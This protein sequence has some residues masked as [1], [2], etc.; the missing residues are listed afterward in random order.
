MK[1]LTQLKEFLKKFIRVKKNSVKLIDIKKD[2]FNKNGFELSVDSETIFLLYDTENHQISYITEVS[3]F[4][5]DTE[6]VTTKLLE[7]DSVLGESRFWIYKNSLF[8]RSTKILDNINYAEFSG[9]TSNYL[10]TLFKIKNNFLK[11]LG[12]DTANLWTTK[13]IKCSRLFTPKS[14]FESDMITKIFNTSDDCVKKIFQKTIT[15][16]CPY[17]SGINIIKIYEILL[18]KLIFMLITIKKNIHFEKNE[19]NYTSLVSF[20]SLTWKKLL[21]ECIDNIN[22][23]NNHIFSV[24]LPSQRE[25]KNNILNSINALT[26][27][28]QMLTN[29]FKEDID[30]EKLKIKTRAAFGEILL[31]FK[32]ADWYEKIEADDLFPFIMT[33]P[34]THQKL[35][36]HKISSSGQHLIFEEPIES[37]YTTIPLENMTNFSVLVDYLK[38]YFLKI[39]FC[40]FKFK[41]NIFLKN[42]RPKWINFISKDL[43]L[44]KEKLLSSFSKKN[45][46]L[47]EAYQ[48]IGIKSFLNKLIYQLTSD[49]QQ[50]T[51]DIQTDVVSDRENF[52]NSIEYLT[53][54]FVKKSDKFLLSKNGSEL[55][56]IIDSIESLYG[57][58]DLIEKI[59]L[60]TSKKIIFITTSSKKITAAKNI[61]DKILSSM[62]ILDILS[63]SKILAYIDKPLFEK[64]CNKTILNG[65]DYLFMLISF[66]K[67]KNIEK[68][69]SL[70]TIPQN[71]EDLIQEIIQDKKTSKKRILKNTISAI[72]L[73]GSSIEDLT[74]QQFLIKNSL[75]NPEFIPEELLRLFDIKE[76]H[77]N[78]KLQFKIKSLPIEKIF[79][80][81]LKKEILNIQNALKSEYEN[82]NIKLKTIIS[83]LCKIKDEKNIKFFDLLNR[84]K[85]KTDLF[86]LWNLLPH[87]KSILGNVPE[88]F[89]YTLKNDNSITQA[90]HHFFSTEID[91]IIKNDAFKNS[92]II[93]ALSIENPILKLKSLNRLYGHLDKKPHEK[94]TPDNHYSDTLSILEY[95]KIPLKNTIDSIFVNQNS[96]AIKTAITNINKFHNT[97]ISGYIKS[98]ILQNFINKNKYFEYILEMELDKKTVSILDDSFLA[99]IFKTTL[100][101]SEQIDTYKLNYFLTNIILKMSPV[102]AK[103]I[104][105]L[106]KKNTGLIENYNLLS[107]FASVI[108]IESNELFTE[109]LNTIP[110]DQYYELKN[111][112]ITTI[113]QAANECSIKIP[114]RSLSILNNAVLK[115]SDWDLN[116]KI[117]QIIDTLIKISENFPDKMKNNLF[118]M[119]IK[120][121]DESIICKTTNDSIILTEKY[122]SLLPQIIKNNFR[123]GEKVFLK[124]V[125]MLEKIPDS[126]NLCFLLLNL[127]YNAKSYGLKP[128]STLLKRGLLLIKSQFIPNESSVFSL[129]TRLAPREAIQSINSISRKNTES[130]ISEIFKNLD[131]TRYDEY[132]HLFIKT[133]LINNDENLEYIQLV[134]ALKISLALSSNLSQKIWFQLKPYLKKNHNRWH[135][136]AKVIKF[137]KKY[138]IFLIT[139][140]VNFSTGKLP[141]ITL[142]K[143]ISR[144]FSINPLEKNKIINILLNLILKLINNE[145]FN[146]KWIF[147]INEANAIESPEVRF[148]QLINLIN[149]FGKKLLNHTELMDNNCHKKNYQEMALKNNLIT[150]SDENKIIKNKISIDETVINSYFNDQRSYFSKK[151]YI[152]LWEK[153]IQQIN[154]LSQPVFS[155]LLEQKKMA[156]M[157]HILIYS[158]AS[159]LPFIKK[160]NYKLKLARIILPYLTKNSMHEMSKALCLY[161]ISDLKILK[162]INTKLL[163]SGNMP[164][165]EMDAVKPLKY[166]PEVIKTPNIILQRLT[167]KVAIK[168]YFFNLE[169]DQ[170][171]N[172]TE[173]CIA[174]N[175]NSNI[176]ELNEFFDILKK[177]T[178]NDAF[179]TKKIEKLYGWSEKK[180]ALSGIEHLIKLSKPSEIEKIKLFIKTYIKILR[181]DDSRKIRKEKIDQL[182]ELLIK[183]SYFDHLNKPFEYKFNEIEHNEIKNMNISKGPEIIIAAI[184][185]TL[186]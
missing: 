129:L 180:Y 99:N 11:N 40:F 76:K 157:E 12:I 161:Y 160:E 103:K 64:I 104:F 1:F 10:K 74:I 131:P 28:H 109:I 66:L 57:L 115:K 79:K 162:N 13:S 120:L 52:K 82:G 75:Y 32:Q 181:K 132:Y 54:I 7:A 177:P 100:K 140:F 83:V 112:R 121:L 48:T 39:P 65:C 87:L 108:A 62:D 67:S 124:A 138:S 95:I 86:E 106:I 27:F 183:K 35:Y 149:D 156:S 168:E 118:N 22:Q 159:I 141:I 31:I 44:T 9:F 58:D 24:K 154:M 80:K 34:V 20:N 56:I 173:Q 47:I 17:D 23:E 89:E 107:A 145:D 36:F 174:R 70:N 110:E 155:S 46:I 163:I 172:Y 150:F 126:G 68:Y 5:P 38:S 133:I 102:R 81:L 50:L 97:Y 59:T 49:I 179:L 165:D 94:N 21:F 71:T 153:T 29:T 137:P 178:L 166:I 4:M 113:C 167:S 139:D 33:H 128:S 146:E 77:Q 130:A 51:S 127:A 142:C 3:P 143:G 92:L 186:Q 171:I 122:T 90:I 15:Q 96:I 144:A 8:L 164:E 148:L 72:L 41:D 185:N 25:L 73:F 84:S 119:G 63:Y 45:S 14:K 26:E 61:D 98:C 43:S 105:T 169:T 2:L 91:L 101:T 184:R 182:I 53:E 19:I 170:L 134:S 114:Q 151:D 117:F 16:E 55:F 175:Q 69:L 176:T 85:Q 123:L 135:K 60:K 125:N 111:L 30:F 18:K 37:N 116:D 158:Y 6:E 78:K 147:N 88:L 136:F 42:D 93:L 152:S